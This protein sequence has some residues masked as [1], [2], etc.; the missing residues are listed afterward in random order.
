MTTGYTTAQIAEMQDWVLG[1]TDSDV[2]RWV[3]RNYD[4]GVAQFMSD[5]VPV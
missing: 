4:G 1:M 3:R 2:V 5:S